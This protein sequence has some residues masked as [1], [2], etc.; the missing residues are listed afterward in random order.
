[1]AS[2]RVAE[3]VGFRKEAIQRWG[4]VFPLGKEGNEGREGEGKGK[5]RDVF[6]LSLCWD[7]WEGG[8]REVV[9]GLLRQ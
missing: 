3:R 9:E 6:K 2:L 8:M 5:G 7:D 4:A 1:M